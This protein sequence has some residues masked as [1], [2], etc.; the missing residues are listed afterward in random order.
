MN[1]KLLLTLLIFICGCKP[2]LESITKEEVYKVAFNNPEEVEQIRTAIYDSIAV[3][4]KEKVERYNMAPYVKMKI[5]TLICFNKKRDK[6]ITCKLNSIK[7][8]HSL[9]DISYFYGVKINRQWYFFGGPTFS[10]ARKDKRKPPSFELLSREAYREVFQYYLKRS[11][12]GEIEIDETFF[13]DLTSGA[14]Y[15]GNGKPEPYNKETW[16]KRY[17]EIVSENRSKID[18]NDYSKMR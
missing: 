3:W 12:T 8:T 1:Q 18:T 11:E 16:D 5:D 13:E 6:F 4:K 14:W 9:D 2:S 10:I 7:S 15:R 17:L